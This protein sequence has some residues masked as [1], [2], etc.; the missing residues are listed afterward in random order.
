MGIRLREDVGQHELEQLPLHNGAVRIEADTMEKNEERIVGPRAEAVARVHA[1]RS[2]RNC[3]QAT[4]LNPRLMSTRRRN[5]TTIMKGAV[6]NTRRTTTQLTTKSPSWYNL[7]WS[8]AIL[9][10]FSLAFDGVAMG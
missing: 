9:P 5:T 10:P 1:S 2:Q 3:R 4:V 8:E 7:K 6:F